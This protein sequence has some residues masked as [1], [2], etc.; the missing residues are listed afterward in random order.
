MQDINKLAEKTLAVCLHHNWERTWTQAGCCLHLEASEFIESLRGK[1][2]EIPA[3]E[4]ADVLFVLLSTLQAHR[5]SIPEVLTHL[6]RKC[7]EALALP[8]LQGGG[9]SQAKAALQ[10]TTSP[11]TARSG[12]SHR[13]PV[14]GGGG[15]FV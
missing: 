3:A 1:G 2:D 9:Y 4:A 15:V 6:D 10:N 11:K 7:D 5:I 8:G 13:A 12:D 14:E